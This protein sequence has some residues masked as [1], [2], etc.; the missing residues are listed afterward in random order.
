[1]SKSTIPMAEVENLVRR[2]APDLGVQLL[3][4]AGYLQVKAPNGHRVNIQKSKTLGHV[5]TTLDVLGQPG[6]MPLKNGPGSNGSIMARIEPTL[7]FVEHFVRMLSSAEAAKKASGPRPFS[8]RQA[9][10]PR[11]PTPV[12]EPIP[13]KEGPYAGKPAELA[14]RLQ[15]IADRSR[16]AKIRRYEEQGLDVAT[17]TAVVDG[18]IDARDVVVADETKGLISTDGIVTGGGGDLSGIEEIEQ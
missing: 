3:E 8:V 4:K 12:A 11:K 10:A 5:D 18:K 15:M 9:P 6:T 14:A 16:L 17:A 2:I 13:S 1:M 7:E